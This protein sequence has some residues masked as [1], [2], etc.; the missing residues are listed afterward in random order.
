MLRLRPCLPWLLRLEM[1][2]GRL[3][4]WLLRLEMLRG[5]LRPW[6]P[7]LLRGGLLRGRL[8]PW[9]LWLLNKFL[10]SKGSTADPFLQVVRK[11]IFIFF[12]FSEDQCT[13]L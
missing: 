8:R 11:R 9:L 4:P 12:F 10:H 2:R 5:R 1:L 7:W 6:L 13:G 3:R